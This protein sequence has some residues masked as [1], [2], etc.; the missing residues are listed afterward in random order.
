MRGKTKKGFASVVIERKSWQAIG[1]NNKG[2]VGVSTPKRRYKS[3]RRRDTENSRRNVHFGCG[4]GVETLDQ[5]WGLSADMNAAQRM[6][7]SCTACNKSHTKTCHT[8]NNTQTD[9]TIGKRT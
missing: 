4:R 8:G 7:I 5:E 2:L 6:T 9:T 3:N 1:G